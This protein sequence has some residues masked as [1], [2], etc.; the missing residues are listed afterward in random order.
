MIF[1]KNFVLFFCVSN[2]EYEFLYKKK[3]VLCSITWIIFNDSS[4]TLRILWNQ[5]LC[6]PKISSL[7]IQIHVSLLE[8]KYFVFYK[9]FWENLIS[10]MNSTFVSENKVEHSIT[11][12]IFNL[13]PKYKLQKKL[14]GIQSKLNRRLSLNVTVSRN[15]IKNL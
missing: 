14:H 12:A 3:I 13:A 15:L 2:V 11:W 1:W 8:K 7:T 10:K 6:I 5:Y 9:F 4:L